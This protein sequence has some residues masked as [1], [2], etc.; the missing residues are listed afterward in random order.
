M[1]QLLLKSS[2]SMIFLSNYNNA[3]TFSSQKFQLQRTLA[4][5]LEVAALEAAA[6]EAAALEAAALEADALEA[7]VHCRPCCHFPGHSYSRPRHCSCCCS[8]MHHSPF[9]GTE[10]CSEPCLVGRSGKCLVFEMYYVL[11]TLRMTYHN[12]RDWLNAMLDR[13]LQF[14]LQL[15]AKCNVFATPQNIAVL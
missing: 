4:P 15:T 13:N 5:A 2:N 9:G 3:L 1:R 14:A 7:L 8:R 10:L 12:K 6:L 11:A